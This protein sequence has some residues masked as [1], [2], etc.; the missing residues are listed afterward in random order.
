MVGSPGTL[1]AAAACPSSSSSSSSFAVQTTSRNPYESRG[2]SHIGGIAATTLQLGFFF[3]FFRPSS[4]QPM[5]PLT[6]SLY[7]KCVTFCLSAVT[8]ADPL[9]SRS[10]MST[11][12]AAAIA[13]RGCREG[14]RGRE[15]IPKGT[16]VARCPTNLGSARRRRGRGGRGTA[17]TATRVTTTTTKRRRRRAGELKG[18]RRSSI[19][20]GCNGVLTGLA[21]LRTAHCRQR[22]EE[23]SKSGGYLLS[24]QG[25]R[26]TLNRSLP[27]RSSSSRPSI[28]LSSLFQVPIYFSNLASLLLRSPRR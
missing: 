23:E 22:R 27:L 15:T 3:S 11:V 7:P 21:A 28:P 26:K 25:D 20:E 13:V 9:Y 4:A 2:F 16:L 6:P 17:H 5:L 8:M 18:P 19:C 24:Q 10:Q 12:A 1:M 14:G